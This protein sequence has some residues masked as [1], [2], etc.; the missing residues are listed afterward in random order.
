MACINDYDSSF[1]H[2]LWGAIR[3]SSLLKCNNPAHKYH[4]LPESLVKRAKI[5]LLASQGIS[6][7]II[8]QKVGLHY[9]NV[10]TWRNRFLQ[11]LPFLQEIEASS[12]EKLEEEIRRI[13]S[14]RKRS[15]T[16]PEF[17]SEQ[18]LAIIDLAC[19]SP[20]DLGY[21]VSQWSLPLLVTEI[22]KQ[23]IADRISAKSVS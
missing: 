4:C 22:Q 10:T 5:I 23:K 13:L 12:P 21:E 14:D 3:E 20:C 11:A 6:N 17:T 7:Q 2:G 8:S 15:G 1:E 16:P 18:I 9:N 19:K